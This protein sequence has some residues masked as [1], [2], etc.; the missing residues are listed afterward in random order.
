MPSHCFPSLL[1]A[2]TPSNL[3]AFS[4]CEGALEHPDVG[5]HML[6]HLCAV[7]LVLALKWHRVDINRAEKARQ[8]TVPDRMWHLICWSAKCLRGTKLS[9]IPLL[10]PFS[11]SSVPILPSI[12]FLP[13]FY[14]VIPLSL[15]RPSL[16]CLCLLHPTYSLPLLW[17]LI[18]SSAPSPPTHI[19]THLLSVCAVL[20]SC[21]IFD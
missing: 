21:A 18:L 19:S 20:E 14:Y 5:V 7:C 8:I 17:W 9:F 16:L 6:V 11:L 12:D 1:L 15:L 13:P 4:Q 3:P 10:F 2:D